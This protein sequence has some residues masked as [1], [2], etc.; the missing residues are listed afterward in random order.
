MHHDI[1][2][3]MNLCFIWEC[4]GLLSKHALHQAKTSQI[5]KYIKAKYEIALH[6]QSYQVKNNIP[7]AGIF[8]QIQEEWK[9][10]SKRPQ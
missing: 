2:E 7:N 10:K 9:N 8:Q 4:F 6:I 5:I 3:S 1:N